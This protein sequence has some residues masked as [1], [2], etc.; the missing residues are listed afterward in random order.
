MTSYKPSQVFASVTTNAPKQEQNW[1]PEESPKKSTITKQNEIRVIATG[2]VTVSPDRCKV[3]VTVSSAKDRVE[4]VKESISR[5]LDYI[6]KALQNEQVKVLEHYNIT[7]DIRLYTYII[8]HVYQL[9][10]PLHSL[11]CLLILPM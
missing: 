6:V 10:L 7:L 11:I 1:F 8:V 3:T 9:I 4:D 5:R 2:E